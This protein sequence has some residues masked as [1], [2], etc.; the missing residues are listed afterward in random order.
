MVFP[1]L[2]CAYIGQAAFLLKNQTSD[3]VNYTFY[4]SVPSKVL[5]ILLKL[6]LSLFKCSWELG[7]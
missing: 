3:D 2:M 1:S 5:Y 7:L 4:R 6:H